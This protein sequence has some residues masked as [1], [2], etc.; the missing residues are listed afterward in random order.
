MR[1]LVSAGVTHRLEIRPIGDDAATHGIYSVEF[2][3]EPL[4]SEG[5]GRVTLPPRG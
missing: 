3:V 1:H 4:A 5:L 2:T